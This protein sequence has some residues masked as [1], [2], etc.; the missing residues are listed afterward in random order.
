MA[1]QYNIICDKNKKMEDIKYSILSL[2]TFLLKYFFIFLLFY[3]FVILDFLI[4]K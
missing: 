1:L 3:Y 2:N 4:K